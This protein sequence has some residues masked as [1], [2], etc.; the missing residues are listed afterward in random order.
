MTIAE[1]DIRADSKLGSQVNMKKGKS[2]V[3]A[4]IDMVEAT[5]KNWYMCQPVTVEAALKAPLESH[6]CFVIVTVSSDES[7]RAPFV[8][9]HDKTMEKEDQGATPRPLC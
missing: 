4:A 7:P 9:L 5:R 2:P 1:I 6:S 8:T 3:K